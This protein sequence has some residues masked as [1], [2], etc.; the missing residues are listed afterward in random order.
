MVIAIIALLIGILLPALGKARQTAQQTVCLSNMRQLGVA[1]ALYG[2]DFD[3]HSMPTGLF[4]TTKGPRNNRGDLNLINW[5]YT[6]NHQ[7]NRRR[8]AGLLLDYVDN[9][10]EIVECPKNK[11]KD[12][13]GIPEDPDTI[14]LRNVYGDGELNFDYTFNA[15][16]QGAKDQTD[17][18]V[19]MF[20][21][22]APD[23]DQYNSQQ[24]AQLMEDGMVARMEGL[25]IIIEESSW[26]FNNHS[27]L[28]STDGEW[29]NVDQWTT[30]H[31]GGGATYFKDGHVSVFT[32]PEGFINDDPTQSYGDTGFTSWDIYI[33]ANRRADYYRL[34]D[35]S[36]AQSL[37]RNGLN[38]RFGAINHPERYR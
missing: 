28:G 30:R 15:P 38:P 19:Y 7:G 16:A 5:A 36:D 34:Y 3:G 1:D 17:F 27:N 29:G 13:H 10:T 37:A 12:P 4:Q 25:P 11:R 8:G 9:A 21:E 23:V 20:K 14:R 31:N 18:D 32:P 6:Y 35:I 26:W 33:R 2:M 22:A 24:I